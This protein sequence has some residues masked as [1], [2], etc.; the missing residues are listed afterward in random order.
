MIKIRGKFIGDTERYA[1]SKNIVYSLQFHSEG[2]AVFVDVKDYK[3]GYENTLV[4][5]SMELFLNSWQ[6]E[7]VQKKARR[8]RAFTDFDRSQYFSVGEV[9]E[10][11]GVSTNT[12]TNWVKTGRLA[13]HHRLK[14]RG[15][16]RFAREDCLRLHEALA[17]GYE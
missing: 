10:F 17:G 2:M 8:T 1:L 15:D 14:P 12:I 13:V 6:F 4:F 9:A 5:G 11:F 7:G 3:S 16:R